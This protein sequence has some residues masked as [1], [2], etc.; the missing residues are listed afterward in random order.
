MRRVVPANLFFLFLIFSLG[1]TYPGQRW[2]TLPVVSLDGIF[3]ALLTAV[4]GNALL[5]MLLALIRTS[6]IPSLAAG[7]QSLRVPVRLVLLLSFTY[8]QIFIVGEELER[9]HN[10]AAARCFVPRMNL[11]TYKTYA[12]LIA[13]SLLRSM[14]RA[15]RIHNAMAM[16]GFTGEFRTLSEGGPL[17]RRDLIFAGVLLLIAIGLLAMDLGAL[18]WA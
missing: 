13:Y 17:A 6:G 4:K 16:R 9:M 8:R 2:D 7:L 14:D 18:S 5:L 15:K 12:H 3:V 10:A 11:H 1:L